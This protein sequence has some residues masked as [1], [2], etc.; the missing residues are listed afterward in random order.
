M[1]KPF[2]VATK[3]LVA[4][5]PQ[6]WLDY[7]GL[8]GTGVELVDA[9]LS[10]VTSEADRVI[11]VRQPEYLAHIELQASYDAEMGERLLRYN[12]LLYYR[13]RLPV[14]SV[15]VLLWRQ[16]DGPA[17]SGIA[18]HTVPDSDGRLELRYRVIRVWEKPVAE[19][20]E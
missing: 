20:L 3:H 17:M 19:L 2:D 6:A 1:A 5:Q 16:A 4:V 7:V 9:D 13:F 10:T 11:H 8:H 15:V 18:G 12:A 14:Q